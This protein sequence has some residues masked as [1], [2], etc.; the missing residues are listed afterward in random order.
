MVSVI[1]VGSGDDY[2]NEQLR[3]IQDTLM[4][5][6]QA[7]VNIHR[8]FLV[9]RQI[10]LTNVYGSMSDDRFITS[11][12]T[13]EDMLA[14]YIDEKYTDNIKKNKGDDKQLEDFSK[15]LNRTR[16]PDKRNEYVFT[17]R[18][19]EARLKYRALQR[20]IFRSGLE[21]PKDVVQHVH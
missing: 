5:G 13:L 19:Q 21:P 9:E 1:T 3:E 7:S 15:L 11:V 18:W 12:E 17:K 8:A 16:D 20:L 6:Q 14:G 2:A 4:E 10:L